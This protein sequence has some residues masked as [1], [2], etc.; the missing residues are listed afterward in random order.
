MYR[1]QEPWLCS[2]PPGSAGAGKVPRSASLRASLLRA[3]RK[4]A[5]VHDDLE[6]DSRGGTLRRLVRGCRTTA[7]PGT[8]IHPN[9]TIT[10]HCAGGTAVVQSEREGDL[11]A[12]G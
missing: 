9:P 7:N 3:R 8:A 4:K 11:L 2:R 1:R 6:V 5:W 12:V 10:G